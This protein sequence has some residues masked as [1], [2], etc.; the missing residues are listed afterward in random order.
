MYKRHIALALVVG[1]FFSLLVTTAVEAKKP[2]PPPPP[3]GTIY[4]HLGDD[5]YQMDIDGENKTLIPDAEVGSASSDLHGGKRWFLMTQPVAGQYPT[6]QGRQELFVVDEDGTA[7]QLTNDPSLM[8]WMAAW[9]PDPAVGHDAGVAAIGVD[10]TNWPSY[11]GGVYRA[12]LAFSGG[13]Y[14]NA[15]TGLASAPSLYV[16]FPLVEDG[17]PLLV[18]DVVSCSFAP[19]GE[20]FTYRQRSSAQLWVWHDTGPSLLVS[21]GAYPVWSPDGSKIVYSWL[22]IYTVN[23][24]GSKNKRIARPNAKTSLIGPSWSPDSA[25]VLYHVSYHTE[26]GQA[27]IYRIGADGSARKNLTDDIDGPAYSLGWTE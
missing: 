1:V 12:D 6:G 15:I 27:D 25:S 19:D 20:E 8:L 14:D 24:D 2:V 16:D 23:P 21:E 17:A 9:T 4:Y 7:V 26:W 3:T 22:G 18:P 13:S 11:E 5:V 10:L